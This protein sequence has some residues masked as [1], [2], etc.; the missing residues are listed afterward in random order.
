MALTDNTIKNAK[1]KEK[2]YKITDEKGMYDVNNNAN[3]GLNFGI[4][5]GLNETQKRIVD[6]IIE[7]PEITI[8]QIA[9]LIQVTKRS[10][11]GNISQL[12]KIGIIERV[13]A[14]KKGYWVVKKS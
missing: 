8:E 6:Y 7:N 11:E 4:N 12:K 13:G 1:P 14:R 9:R 3:V 2:Q 5:F 10:V